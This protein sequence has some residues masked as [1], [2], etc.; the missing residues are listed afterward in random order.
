MQILLRAD[1]GRTDNQIA[2]ALGIGQSTAE[3][4]R[5]EFVP[6]GV[7]RAIANPKCA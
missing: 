1:E 4:S 7:E 6:S 3:R 5:R 2:E